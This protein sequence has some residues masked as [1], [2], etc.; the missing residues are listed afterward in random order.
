[1]HALNSDLNCVIACVK[2]IQNVGILDRYN[3][4]NIKV[5]AGS[6]PV[7][8]KDKNESNITSKSNTSWE[9]GET[10]D[11]PTKKNPKMFQRLPSLHL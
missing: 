11:T 9:V 5:S 4:Y 7:I 8:L 1:M 10:L 6:L 2:H 3:R